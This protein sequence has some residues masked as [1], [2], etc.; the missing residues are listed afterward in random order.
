MILYH[1]S[2]HSFTEFESKHIGSINGTGGLGRGFYFSSDK[3]IASSYAR[4]GNRIQ[5]YLY[6]VEAA[7]GEPLSD[8]H[9]MN[10]DFFL[11]IVLNLSN[12]D[13]LFLL[14]YVEDINDREDIAMAAEKVVDM[15][16]EYEDNDVDLINSLLSASPG[17]YENLAN[18]LHIY[19]ITH[20]E[21]SY[22]ANG[23]TYKNY[24]I[25]SNKSFKLKRKEMVF[26]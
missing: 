8:E 14:D 19:N 22:E 21:K 15:L 4:L 3:Q 11:E 20:T 6:K 5:G 26:F 10:R 17:C 24:A 25:L 2:P 7:L 12:A 18:I 9:K 1:G 23:V 13:P 16:Y